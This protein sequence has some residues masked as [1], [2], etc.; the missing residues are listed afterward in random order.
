MFTLLL[1]LPSSTIFPTPTRIL[2]DP[3]PNMLKNMCGVFNTN[4]VHLEQYAQLRTIIVMAAHQRTSLFKKQI[5][6]GFLELMQRLKKNGLSEEE[7]TRELVKLGQKEARTLFMSAVVKWILK[8]DT[9]DLSRTSTT[10]KK[11]DPEFLA[12]QARFKKEGW[13]EERYTKALVDLAQRKKAET[14]SSC[15]M[16][17]DEW[18]PTYTTRSD[19]SPGEG[20]VV[21]PSQEDIE[22]W[23]R[24]QDSCLRMPEVDM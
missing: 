18:K 10:K 11:S 5:D 6:E 8:I 20:W 17:E 23:E 9:P 3:P 1:I 2:A 7:F 21:I 15:D 24:F 22:M 4:V 12:L 13:S 14:Q 19:G 16:T